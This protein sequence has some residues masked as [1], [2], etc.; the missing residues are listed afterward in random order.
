MNKFNY[1]IPVLAL[2]AAS[3]G[4][5]EP[6]M[7]GDFGS[8][9]IAATNE[10]AETI[11]KDSPFIQAPDGGSWKVIGEGVFSDQLVVNSY[12]MYEAGSQW[13]VTIEQSTTE[14]GWYRTIPYNKNWP[15]YGVWGILDDTE[16]LYINATD[17]DKVYCDVFDAFGNLHYFQVVPENEEGAAEIAAGAS[18]KYGT[19]K[20]NIISFPPESH[21]YAYIGQ[22]SGQ[23]IHET[24]NN[25]GLLKIALPGGQIGDLWED[26]GQ[27][28]FVDGIMSTLQS[29]VST[30]PS[31]KVNIQ[32][33]TTKEGVYRITDPWVETFGS[34][35]PLEIDAS[36]PDCVIIKEQSVGVRDSQMGEIYIL[37]YSHH[38]VERSGMSK[39][40][41]KAKYGQY[42]ITMKDGV[43]AI[44]GNACLYFFPDTDGSNLYPSNR[45]HESSITLPGAGI[46]SPAVDAADAPVEY[47]NL[48]GI[49]VDN[50]VN[51]IYI[52]RQGSEISKIIL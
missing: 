51:G 31:L 6:V 12:Q 9:T 17:P 45:P 13:P 34:T 16:Y 22:S 25:D 40:D 43:I 52:R 42:N 41:F 3:A 36:D 37:S 8:E 33:H 15:M 10:F 50:P 11:A 26:M 27:G 38:F 23:L 19:L 32:R 35:E 2:T 21:I 46:D 44:P 7:T 20:D 47:Y 29:T 48:Q 18:P 14:P 4:A 5:A 39:A 24:A 49:R 1:L 28:V 30:A